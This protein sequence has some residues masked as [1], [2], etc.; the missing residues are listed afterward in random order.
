MAYDPIWRDGPV[1]GGGVG[2][3]IGAPGIYGWGWHD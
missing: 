3:T 2:V 1:Y